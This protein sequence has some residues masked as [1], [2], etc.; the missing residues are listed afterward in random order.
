M[1]TSDL[2]T[3]APVTHKTAQTPRIGA[4][5]VRFANRLSRN[6]PRVHRRQSPLH[7][8]DLTDHP[9]RYPSLSRAVTAQRW[10][11]QA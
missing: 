1:T 5:G 9:P 11:P 7:L 3:E 4:G 6:D 2:M 10:P 8:R